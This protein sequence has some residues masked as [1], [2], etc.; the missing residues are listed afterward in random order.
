VAL[1]GCS[2]LNLVRLEGVVCQNEI[3]KKL[4]PPA[5]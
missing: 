3:R 4:E 2:T 1:S 5:L